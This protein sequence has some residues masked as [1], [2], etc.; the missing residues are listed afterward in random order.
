MLNK[1]TVTYNSSVTNAD[2]DS[3]EMIN[4]QNTFL[5]ILWR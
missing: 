5:Q 3:K 4:S 2:E 1:P